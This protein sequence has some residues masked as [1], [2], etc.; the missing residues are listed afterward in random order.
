MAREHV[1]ATV[2]AA[3]DVILEPPRPLMRELP[4]ADPFPVGALGDV[5][6]PAA[7][8]I[9][10]RVQAPLAICGQS[11]LAAA[12]LAVQGHADIELPTGQKRPLTNYYLTIAATG[13][14]KTAV[15]AEALWPVRKRERA[16]HERHDMERHEYENSRLAWE[17]ARDTATKNAKPKGDRVAIKALL[18]LLG[19]A[20]D[21]PLEP[22]LICPEPTYEGLCKLFLVGQPSLGIFASE[23]GQFIGG[24]GMSDDAKLRTAAGLS[25]AWDGEAIKRVRADGAIVL[26]GRPLAMH[27]MAQPDV[28]SALLNDPV[29]ADQGMLSRVLTTAPDAASGTRIW[30]EPSPE[31]NSVMQRY[32]ARLLDILELPLPLDSG[33]QNTLAPRALPLSGAARRLWI[34]FYNHIEERVASGRELEPVRGLANKIPEHAARIAAV[35][36]IVHDI[37]ASEVVTWAIESGIELAQHFATEA[38]RLYGASRVNAEVQLAL[39]LLNWLLPRDNLLVSLPCIY[40]QGPAAIRDKA[41]ATKVTAIL[42]DHGY[43]VPIPDGAEIEGR[44]RRDV[45]RVVR[46]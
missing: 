20:P 6:A 13:E 29:L 41:R 46:E 7:R 44:W 38:L 36:T 23:G 32:G 4:P 21:A 17:K 35:L 8:A 39:H 40:Q 19:P 34:G 5:L 1:Q 42:E 45:W 24:H 15:D 43:L 2:T 26:S 22:L 37:R 16:L 14:R 25:A 12:T 10:N 28:A 9:N 30:R 3:R 33:T 31:S 11:V 18:D 27:L